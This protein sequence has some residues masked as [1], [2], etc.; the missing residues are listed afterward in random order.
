MTPQTAAQVEA[1]CIRIMAD[2]RATRDERDAAKLV[3]LAAG[4]C[5]TPPRHAVDVLA[6]YVRRTQEQDR[7]GR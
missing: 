1:D 2:D 4:Y 6:G 7:W 3:R 5:G